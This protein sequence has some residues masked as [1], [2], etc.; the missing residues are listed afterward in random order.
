[1]PTLQDLFPQYQPLFDSLASFT[2]AS[3]VKEVIQMKRY[4]VDEFIKDDD[5]LLIIILIITGEEE[6]N[7]DKVLTLIN[8]RSKSVW[9]FSSF[10]GNLGD[11]FETF[12]FESIKVSSKPDT[13]TFE[14]T[15]I[16]QTELFSVRVY[17][18]EQ[19]TTFSNA[20]TR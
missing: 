7:Q 16:G 10:A 2:S 19:F 6:A 1:M 9:V 3:D 5:D 13:T 15:R 14:M 11:E 18:E 17:E 4:F 8:T 12:K 20:G